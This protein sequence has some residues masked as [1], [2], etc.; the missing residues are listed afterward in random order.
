MM[1]LSCG[2][3]LLALSRAFTIDQFTPSEAE[4]M[5]RFMSNYRKLMGDEAD[6]EA[7]APELARQGPIQPLPSPIRPH[8]PPDPIEFAKTCAGWVAAT[9]CSGVFGAGIP[10]EI[11]AV[12]DLA[13]IG[14]LAGTYQMD[15]D[16]KTVVGICRLAP[17]C[18]TPANFTMKAIWR[19]GLGCTMLEEGMIEEILRAQ[20][21]GNQNPPPPLDPNTPWPYGEGYFPENSPP[22]VDRE[23]LA[24]AAAEDFA[25]VATNTRAIT[26]SFK[27]YLVFEQ[28]KPGITKDMR[29]MG[30]SATKS[31]T[32][33]LVGIAMGESGKSIYDPAPVWEWNEDPEDLRRN[34][35]TDMM[36]RM[37]AGTRWIGDLPPTTECLY[38]SDG[39]CAHTSALQPLVAEPDTEWN[40]NSGSTYVLSRIA[41]ESRNSP[42]WNNFEWP[43]Q[44][45]FYPIGAHNIHIEYQQNKIFLGGSYGYGTAR[46]WLRFGVLHAND[47][48][49]VDGTRVL[50]AGWSQYSRTPSHTNPSYAGHFWRIPSLDP[51]MFYA[52][53]FRNENVFIF[54]RQNIVITRHAMPFPAM[55]PV[56]RTEA[57]L[58]SMLECF[59]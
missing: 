57:F 16:Q 14:N 56:F 18:C 25:N 27:N 41:L 15:Y 39:D 19:Q 42:E 43:K 34:I 45:L 44:K 38:Y 5:A 58:T 47:G 48:V 49:W 55:H 54:P 30:W 17:G 37:S 40:Y 9:M 32:G 52:S 50:P 3:V 31:L 59:E 36:L 26:V 29:L 21:T 28:Y 35:T 12:E 46:D 7:E 22:G 23:C 24:R 51:D 20:D 2:L 1:L 13:Y 33:T 4:E 11:V 10:E 6:L 8:P 53:G